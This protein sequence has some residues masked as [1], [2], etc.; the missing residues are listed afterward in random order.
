MSKGR[1][2]PRPLL[3]RMDEP[4]KPR[5][6]SPVFTRRE[7]PHVSRTLQPQGQQPGYVFFLRYLHTNAHS[8]PFT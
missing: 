7:S 1:L 2:S 4:A 3:P 6:A 5:A 8:I